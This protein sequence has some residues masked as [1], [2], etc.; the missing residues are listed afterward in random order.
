MAMLESLTAALHPLRRSP[1]A[2]ETFGEATLVS[3]SYNR[4]LDDNQETAVPTEEERIETGTRVYKEFADGWIFGLVI[5]YDEAASD[6]IVEYD[7]GQVEAFPVGAEALDE[8]I[9]SAETFTGFEQG[10]PV[11]REED[12]ATGIIMGFQ[13]WIYTIQWDGDGSME[14]LSDV[15]AGYRPT[16]R[17]AD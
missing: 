12:R 7:N 15:T 9:H 6:Y 1:S 10:T 17:T 13:D 5:E 14:R 16:N 3:T 8:I 2:V 4:H 11:Y